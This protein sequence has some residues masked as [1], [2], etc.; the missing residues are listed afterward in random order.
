MNDVAVTP[1]A[2]TPRT[3]V[4][5]FRGQAGQYFRIWIVNM[6]LSILTLGIY[7]AWAKVRTKR[8]FYGSTVLDGAS[9]E[10]HGTPWQ[11]LKGRLIAVAVIAAYYGASYVNPLAGFVFLGVWLVVLP[12]V[13][14]LSLRFN[15]RVSSY[16]NV[17][18][19][20]VGGYWRAL[21]AFL[22]LPML[23]P[24][25][26]FLLAPVAHRYLARYLVQGYRFGGRPFSA[27]LRFGRFYLIYLQVAGT[28]LLGFLLLLGVMVVLPMPGRP[29]ST[30]MEIYFAFIPAILLYTIAL[31]AV[32]FVRAKV[33]NVVFNALVLEGGHRFASGLGPWRMA[34]IAFSNLLVIAVTLGLM[35]PWARIRVTRYVAERTAV[36]PASDLSEFVSAL[37]QGQQAFG[38]ELADMAGVDIG[39]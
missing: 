36:Y 14:N 3:L 20:F 37:P 39:I 30:G 16:R 15:A 2:V 1:A 13:A 25:T 24:L 34:W 10:Y 31:L 8:Y 32:P 35:T 38:A 17:R 29:Q 11:I 4:F 21:L 27:E 18:F 12:W 7:S 5:E 23:S 9:F 26:L 22:V 6:V 28:V 33:R 19:D